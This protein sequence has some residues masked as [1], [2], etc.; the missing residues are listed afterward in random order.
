[1]T[2]YYAWRDSRNQRLTS[3]SLA[4]AQLYVTLAAVIR[5]SELD[6]FETSLADIEPCHDGIVALPRENSKVQMLVL[7]PGQD[8]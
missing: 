7:G 5:R 8:G 3:D 1:M 4:Y 2:Y 6:L